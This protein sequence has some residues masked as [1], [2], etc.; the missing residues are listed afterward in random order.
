MS[1]RVKK[2][3]EATSD[4][5]GSST[6]DRGTV[7]GRSF[8]ILQLERRKGTRIELSATETERFKEQ[9]LFQRGF[10]LHRRRSRTSRA[11]LSALSSLRF[12]T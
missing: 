1:L 11:E 8:F 12:Y 7:F 3:D 9:R 6:R 4:E 5:C 2:S 10:K